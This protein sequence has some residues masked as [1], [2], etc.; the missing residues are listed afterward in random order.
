[1][2]FPLWRYGAYAIATAVTVALAT[3]NV[4]A[5]WAL[6]DGAYRTVMI[7]VSLTADVGAPIALV[8][9][10]YYFHGHNPVAV[11]ASLIVWAFCAY[12]EM[13]GAETWLK[14]NSVTL[15]A[16][17]LK[18]TEAQRAAS[19]ELETETGNLADIRKQLAGERRE[20]KLDALQRREKAS[21]ERLEKLRPQTFTPSVEPPKLQF[22]GNE[23]ALAFALWLLSQAAWVM[24]L[25]HAYTT[26]NHIVLGTSDPVVLTV[27]PTVHQETVNAVPALPGAALDVNS[28]H[29]E[30]N[31]D[32][33]VH[34]HGERVHEHPVPPV[35]ALVPRAPFVDQVVSHSKGGLSV[36]QITKKMGCS[37]TKIQ[38]ALKAQKMRVTTQ[39][40]E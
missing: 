36:R 19:A 4:A 30:N 18:A 14:A 33:R 9:M 7:A 22:V 23:R 11:L 40:G 8:A 26:K 37:P 6:D 27:R 5:A 32:E 15:S 34:E 1:M 10:M 17:A 28:Q 25:G 35:L 38:N 24:A 3:A 31:H 39:G 2:Q 13:N 21:L 29:L 20:A 16:P 12:G